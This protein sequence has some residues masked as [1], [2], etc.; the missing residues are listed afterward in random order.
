MRTT[1]I[2]FHRQSIHNPELCCFHLCVKD[3]LWVLCE[4]ISINPHQSHP[5]KTQQRKVERSKNGWVVAGI[6]IW[7]SFA[8]FDT[9]GDA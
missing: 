4:L 7:A 3:S 5:I 6:G 1:V 8:R 2:Q 9:G